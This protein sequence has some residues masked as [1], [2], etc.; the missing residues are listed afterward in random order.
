VRPHLGFVPKER[1]TMLALTIDGQT[2]HI[3]QENQYDAMKR[4]WQAR[5]AGDATAS[6][7]LVPDNPNDIEDE[8][9]DPEPTPPGGV[10][11]IAQQRIQ[12]QE[13]WLDKNG[14]HVAPPL[15][16]PGTRVVELGDQ[17]FKMERRRIESMPLFP[18]AAAAVGYQ[19]AKEQRQDLDLPLASLHMDEDGSLWAEGERL[20]MERG[21]FFQLATAAGFGMGA[22]YLAE[23]C[24]PLLRAENVNAQLLKAGKRAI[25]LRTRRGEDGGRRV[26]ATVTPTYAVVDTHQVLDMVTDVLTDSR[27]EMLYDGTGVHATAL[28]M[29]DSVVDLAAGDIFKS[30]VRVETDDTG[31]GRIRVT[32]VVWRNQC[33]NLIVIAEGEVETVSLV[34][35]G[36]PERIL[37][38]VRDGVEM[39]RSRV[40]DFLESWGHA[41]TVKV[42]VEE[43]L[44]EWVEERKVQVRGVRSAAERDAVVK[45]L[46]T[47]WQQEP[48]D[49]LADAVNAV[50]RAAHEHP[51]WGVDVREELERQ[52]ARLV[53]VPA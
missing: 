41:R 35:R 51:L 42:N 39:A 31:R 8:D 30:G 18:D 25:R 1:E 10:S 2:E 16:A 4:Y 24:D 13:E 53:L 36:D 3:D 34:H 23:K 49:T 19:V 37:S 17:N 5:Q 7:V 32:G 27:A 11:A 38:I 40:A 6:L 22:R 12:R 46:L 28:W 29:P 48:G 47:S 9:D 33:L 43:L 21:S 45:A 20:E 14:F 15:Y 50:T 44:R 52:A 26:F